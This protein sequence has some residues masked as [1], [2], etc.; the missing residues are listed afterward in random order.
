[1]RGKLYRPTAQIG[2]RRV[3]LPVKT[4]YWPYRR[5]TDRPILEYEL[6]LCSDS[7]SLTQWSVKRQAFPCQIHL[8]ELAFS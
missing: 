3:G 2:L 6:T 8:V 7:Q 4:I 1:M 5:K